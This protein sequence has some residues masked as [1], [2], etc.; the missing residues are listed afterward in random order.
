MDH[1][2]RWE[3][4]PQGLAAVKREEEV[5]AFLLQFVGKEPLS[6]AKDWAP[7]IKLIALLFIPRNYLQ[8]S[9]LRALPNLIDNTI[10][11]FVSRNIPNQVAH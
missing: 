5:D 7:A 1:T 2:D 4:E 10:Y 3:G 6:G 11:I 9:I 8:I